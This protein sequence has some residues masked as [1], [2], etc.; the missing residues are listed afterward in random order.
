MKIITLAVA[1]PVNGP[2]RQPSEGALTVSDQEAQRL[3]DAGV[4]ANEP[5]DVPMEDGGDADHEVDGLDDET[6]PELGRIV[7]K[8]G[9]ALNGATKKA[10]IIAAIRAHRAGKE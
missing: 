5:E 9:V 10:D 1:A 6:M 2:L 7:T 8:E 3:H 4:L